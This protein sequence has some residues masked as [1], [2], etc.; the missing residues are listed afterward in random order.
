MKRRWKCMTVL[1]AVLIF[2]ASVSFTASADVIWEPS[3][4]FYMDNLDEC[5]YDGRDYL[6]N[7]KEGFV[8]VYEKPG[9][10]KEVAR[11]KNGKRFYVGFTYKGRGGVT[12]AVLNLWGYEPEAEES[13]KPDVRDGWVVFENLAQVYMEEDFRAEHES[14]FADYQGELD[15]YEIKKELI[16]WDYPGS[17]RITGRVE[18]YFSGGDSPVYQDLYTDPDGNRWT[19]VGYYYGEEGWVCVD[20]PENGELSLS[21]G[22]GAIDRELYPAKKPE[23]EV[24]PPKTNAAV[25]AS[26]GAAVLLVVVVTALLIAVLFRKN[27]K[28][29]GE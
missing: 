18:E 17:G 8:V 11:I 23:G 4:D 14:G 7:G 27:D 10:S 9:D 2:W 22:P 5:E 3:G 20:D 24:M 28:N 15:G 16:F 21:Y 1:G 12:W 6:T 25:M 13:L 19:Y 26:A 29:K